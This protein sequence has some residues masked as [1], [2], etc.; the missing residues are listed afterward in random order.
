MS[1]AAPSLPVPG[2]DAA[3]RAQAGFAAAPQWQRFDLWVLL[4]IL[5]WAV[6]F[7]LLRL[8]LSASVGVDDAEIILLGDSLRLGYHPE[9][10]PLF[11][12]LAVLA[13]Q[14]FGLTLASELAV[15]YLL[16]VL[17][18]AH[19][20]AAA[21]HLLRRP[22]GAGAATLGL[23]LFFHFGYALHLGYTHTVTLLW[24]MAASL[25]L[26]LAMSAARRDWHYAALGLLIG[27]GLLTKPSDLVFLAAVVVAARLTPPVRRVLRD[28]RAWMALGLGLLVAAPWALW[29][30]G[31]FH[32]KGAGGAGFELGAFLARR[33]QAAGKYLLALLA[34]GGPFAALFAGLFL[35]G[36]TRAERRRALDDQ[37]VRFLLRLLIAGSLLMGLY[38]TALGATWI[39]ERHLHGVLF[40]LPLAAFVFLEAAGRPFD[41][42]RWRGRLYLAVALLAL[43]GAAGGVAW[44]LLKPPGDCKPCR[45]QKPLPAL[46]ALLAAEGWSSG[47]LIAG[48]EF[49]AAQIRTLLPDL[50]V[51]TEAYPFFEPA[52]EAAPGA[53]RCLLLWPDPPARDHAAFVALA[54]RVT[55]Q[56]WPA[57]APRVV[58]LPAPGDPAYDWRWNLLEL[59]PAGACR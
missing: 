9:R 6:G 12:W 50:R 26:L 1:A 55:G 35:A 18:A 41:H 56:A 5:A 10:P 2:K 33:A 23:L 40:F 43:A 14:V 36:T 4:A 54:E 38:V 27:L 13:G 58:S 45:Y 57:A 51:Y 46:A 59:P 37:R 30:L 39:R 19:F 53:G 11:N 24:V 44:E 52:G 34:F 3:A 31:A 16:L 21:R 15:K 42:R 22:G 28:R 47:T 17:G 25:H 49:A 48:D 29:A 8:A 7:D 20:Y 32:P